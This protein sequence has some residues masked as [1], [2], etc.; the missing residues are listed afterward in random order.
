MWIRSHASAS[1]RESGALNVDSV[2]RKCTSEGIRST[3]YGFG[4]MQVRQRGNQEHLMWIRSHASAPDHFFLF[5]CFR[6]TFWRDSRGKKSVQSGTALF[7][8]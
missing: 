3:L 1:A 8:K 4:H 5:M 2:T 6:F 7:K